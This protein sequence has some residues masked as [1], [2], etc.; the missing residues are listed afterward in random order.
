[1]LQTIKSLLVPFQCLKRCQTTLKNVKT[2]PFAQSSVPSDTVSNGEAVH[3]LPSA[4][5]MAHQTTTRTGES[6]LRTLRR[7]ACKDKIKSQSSHV[8]L[9][10]S[11]ALG[12]HVMLQTVTLH[13]NSTDHICA[14]HNPS[15]RRRGMSR[16]IVAPRKLPRGRGKF[17]PYACD[18][19]SKHAQEHA[20]KDVLRT[21]VILHSHKSN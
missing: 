5:P 17:L 4:A 20:N 13:M 21:V 1:M 18:D 16:C 11:A 10:A 14:P 15:S 8:V 6:R 2:A 3:F 19:V 9:V 7:S 12:Y